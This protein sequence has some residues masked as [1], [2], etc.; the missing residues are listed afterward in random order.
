MIIEE[1]K[2]IEIKLDDEEKEVLKKA[3]KILDDI[4]NKMNLTK[5]EVNL[6]V[7]LEDEVWGMIDNLDDKISDMI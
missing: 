7:N 3:Y 2:R 5:D 4:F 6:E 1:Y